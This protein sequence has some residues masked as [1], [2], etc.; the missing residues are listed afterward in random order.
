[1]NPGDIKSTKGLLGLFSFHYQRSCYFKSRTRE[2][3]ANQPLALK[4]A[5]IGSN[6]FAEYRCKMHFRWIIF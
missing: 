5:L 3:F 4:Q 2:L 6:V 1:M